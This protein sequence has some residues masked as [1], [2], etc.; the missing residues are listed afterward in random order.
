MKRSEDSADMTSEP[1]QHYYADV[2]IIGSGAAGGCAAIEA[3]DAGANVVLLE[4]QP[5]ATHYSNTRMSG[6][7]FHSG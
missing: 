4:K 3:H 6:G 1:T 2:V 5:E 7:G